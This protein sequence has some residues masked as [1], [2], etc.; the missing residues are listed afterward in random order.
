M[1]LIRNTENLKY[2][3]QKLLFQVSALYPQN[4]NSHCSLLCSTEQRFTIMR[5]E[6][7]LSPKIVAL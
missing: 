4:L 3:N 5:Y 7:P 2:L 1:R 6:N